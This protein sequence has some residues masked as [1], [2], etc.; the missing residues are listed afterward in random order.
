MAR[1]R[2]SFETKRP[3]QLQEEGEK[4]ETEEERKQRAEEQR[5]EEEELARKEKFLHAQ[6][7]FANES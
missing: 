4:E 1:H 3:E 6:K 2:L 5:K 7:M